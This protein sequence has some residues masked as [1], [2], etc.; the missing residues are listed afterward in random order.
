VQYI[1]QSLA[2]YGLAFYTSW[3]L[4]LV[5]L[6]GLPLAAIVMS[7]ISSMMQPSIARQEAEL[8][9][10]SR[11]ANSA[12]SAIE[13]VK[14]FNCQSF[15][16]EQYKSVIFEAARYYLKQAMSNALQIGFIRFV[17]TAMFVQ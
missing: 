1:V 10:A 11:V 4:T 2:S 15:E 13:T 5:I 6:A 16:L 17:T 9:L 7:F 14:S 8:S 3:K 12:L